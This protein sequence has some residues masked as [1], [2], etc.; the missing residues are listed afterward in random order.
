MKKAIKIFCLIFL[1]VTTLPV[2]TQVSK[3]GEINTK[4]ASAEESN[5]KNSEKLSEED[6]KI[7]LN[8]NTQ[9]GSNEFDFIQRNLASSDLADNGHFLLI[10]GIVLVVLSIAGII[11]FSFCL[12]KLCR[13][14]KKRLKKQRRSV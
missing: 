14:T 11:F 13:N 10:T 6:L 9:K 2:S 7:E 4:I 5:N 3:I 1:F 8:E 12:Y